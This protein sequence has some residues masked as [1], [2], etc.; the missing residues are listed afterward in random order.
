MSQNEGISGSVRAAVGELAEHAERAA[1]PPAEQLDLL[2]EMPASRFDGAPT[3][4]T[5]THRTLGE[6]LKARGRPRGAQ[7]IAT[8]EVR[9]L[10]RHLFGDPLLEMARWTLHTP[11]TLARELGCT[12]VEAFDRLQRVREALAPYFYARLA[13]TDSE[14]RPVVPQF[15]MMIGDRLIGADRAPWLDDP[16]VRRALDTP[17]QNQGFNGAGGPMS[18]AEKSQGAAND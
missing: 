16:E 2:A 11:E 10:I 1:G 17:Q 6:V 15:A 4:A 3:A 9:E 8:R 7:N 14:G 12:L 18:H 13:P 5:G